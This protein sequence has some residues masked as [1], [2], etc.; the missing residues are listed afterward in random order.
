M[1]SYCI[2]DLHGRYDL[3]LSILDK[4]HFDESKDILYVLGDV[5]DRNY[6]GIKILAHMMTNQSAYKF[7]VGNHEDKFLSEYEDIYYPIVQNDSLREELIPIYENLTKAYLDISNKV[8][9]IVK[10]FNSSQ[11]EQKGILAWME[12]DIVISVWMSK[13]YKRK[14]LIPQLAQLFINIHYDIELIT[15]INLFLI[16]SFTNYENKEFKRELLK[17]SFHEIENLVQYISKSNHKVDL[18]CN[19]NKFLLIHAISLL[20]RE[21]LEKDTHYVFGHEPIAS[22]HRRTCHILNFDYREILSYKDNSN[23]YFF[24]LDM[25]NNAVAALRLDD[26]EEFYAMISK[27]ESS[28]SRIPPVTSVEERKVGMYYVEYYNRTKY[29]I[30]TFD[31][32]CM[33]YLIETHPRKNEISIIAM[34]EVYMSH[35]YS[36]ERVVVP[37]D[38][39]VLTEDEIVKIAKER[40]KTKDRLERKSWFA[41]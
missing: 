5:I 13:H 30:L 18:E 27:R 3:F 25:S 9:E 23:R 40:M 11:E 24:N 26:F 21:E 28:E 15:K 22:I 35:L 4:L 31:N 20:K 2:G 12:E 1:A 16:T 29:S 39:G 41:I 19:G 10:Q 36:I 8:L 14:K 6:G 33:E 37:V 34:D 32:Y 38:C 17:L 7:V